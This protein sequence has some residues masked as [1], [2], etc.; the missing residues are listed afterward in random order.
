MPAWHR[1]VE[2][3]D[4]FRR[5]ITFDM[6]NSLMR[7]VIDIKRVSQISGMYLVGVLLMDDATLT[8]KSSGRMERS[9]AGGNCFYC[10]RAKKQES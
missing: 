7:S 2:K 8:R 5:L 4:A 3:K 9:P 6:L 1:S 10:V